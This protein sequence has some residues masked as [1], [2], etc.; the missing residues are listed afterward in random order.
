MMTIS[1]EQYLQKARKATIEDAVKV[2]QNKKREETNRK[3][4]AAASLGGRGAK[5]KKPL[6]FAS[7]RS[8]R[9]RIT[10]W[11]SRSFHVSLLA[12]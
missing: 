5:R 2:H 12:A 11:T 9:P 3:A 4:R 1:I 6:L 8:G 7:K 10:F